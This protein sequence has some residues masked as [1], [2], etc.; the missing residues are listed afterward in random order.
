LIGIGVCFNFQS[1]SLWYLLKL[2]NNNLR[3]T[4]TIIPDDDIE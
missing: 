3:K 1:S 2:R 4:S